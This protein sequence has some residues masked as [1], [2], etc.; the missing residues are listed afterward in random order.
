[1]RALEQ[2]RAELGLELLDLRRERR[3]R[4]VERARRAR[5]AAGLEHGD[6]VAQGAQV[7]GAGLASALEQH[8]HRLGQAARLGQEMVEGG[9]EDHGAGDR[10]QQRLPGQPNRGH[11]PALARDAHRGAR[12]LAH[13]AYDRAGEKQRQ[14]DR[15]QRG[16]RQHHAEA[17]AFDANRLGDVARIDR[18]HD[19]AAIG[20][21]GRRGDH[22]GA[23][24][25]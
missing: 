13:R 4:D 10:A 18:G 11:E 7:H 2:L 15:Q 9:A 3:L 20:Q 6:E 24:R 25:R 21:G 22:W 19:D 5:E 23:I 17:V 16:D 12:Q 1:M 8:A 14:Q